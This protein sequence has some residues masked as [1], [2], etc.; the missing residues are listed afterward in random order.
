M[1]NQP[2]SP[3]I[4]H[5]TMAE[6]LRDEQYIYAR[7]LNPSFDKEYGGL[8]SDRLKPGTLYK[9]L[10]TSDGMLQVREIGQIEMS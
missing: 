5:E 8:L 1:N 7:T 10:G 2:I 4:P 6:F 9:V 3:T